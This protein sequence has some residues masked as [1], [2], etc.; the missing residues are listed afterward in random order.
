MI[1]SAAFNFEVKAFVFNIRVNNLCCHY[2]KISSAHSP[3]S[4]FASRAY[5]HS[6]AFFLLSIL[7]CFHSAGFQ[8]Q[9][10][11]IHKRRLALPWSLKRSRSKTLGTGVHH[12]RPYLLHE[13]KHHHTGLLGAQS[14]C[15]RADSYSGR[16]PQAGS[17]RRPGWRRRSDASVPQPVFG[18]L[19]HL[20]SQ[21]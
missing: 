21:G 9:A 1:I 20:L 19:V 16:S 5:F 2:F 10:D 18:F 17:G 3:A 14:R 13:H 8:R 6:A 11:Q 15:Y 7:M 12:R 4:C